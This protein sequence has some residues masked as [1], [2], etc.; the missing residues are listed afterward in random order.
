MAGLG[1]VRNNP[2]VQQDRLKKTATEIYSHPSPPVVTPSSYSSDISSSGYSSPTSNH[3]PNYD[4]VLSRT[5]AAVR[6]KDSSPPQEPIKSPVQ[7]NKAVFE[8]S[9]ASPLKNRAPSIPKP[10]PR[11]ILIEDGISRKEEASDI[12]YGKV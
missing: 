2:W 4:S 8:E 6:L 5:R 7:Q 10:A 11:T 1:F 12:E 3:V 9:L